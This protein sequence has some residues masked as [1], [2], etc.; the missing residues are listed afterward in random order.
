MPSSVTYSYRDTFTG[1][2]GTAY[3]GRASYRYSAPEAVG[4][5]GQVEVSGVLQFT[6]PVGTSYE[7]ILDVANNGGD[8]F[9]QVSSNDAFMI[10]NR[11][12]TDTLTL[13]FDGLS[14]N[15]AYMVLPA[16]THFI[17]YGSPVMI[18]S[19]SGGDLCASVS[20]KFTSATGTVEVIALSLNSAFS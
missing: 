16:G 1:T 18:T 9:G 5:F 13:R 15:H 14:A 20:A 2:G 12:T 4:G 19:A 8:A 6:A 17:L 7:Q 3:G 10:V 11:S